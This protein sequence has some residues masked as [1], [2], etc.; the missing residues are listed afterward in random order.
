MFN[1]QELRLIR[2]AVSKELDD[3]EKKLKIL[4]PDSDDSIEIGN[5][6]MLLRVILEK[7]ANVE[8][9]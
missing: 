6:S 9:V 1:V 3:C 4:D 2:H 7:I 5:D 8:E